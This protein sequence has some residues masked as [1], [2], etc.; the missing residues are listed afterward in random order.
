MGE[1]QTEDEHEG[2]G[3]SGVT[4]VSIEAVCDELVFGVDG[5]VEG[6]E[7]AKSREAV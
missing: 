5:E 2:A 7:M 6:E 1:G 4:D 3:V